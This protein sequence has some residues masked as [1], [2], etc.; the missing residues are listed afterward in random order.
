MLFRDCLDK[1]FTSAK[2]C[3]MRNA[4][5]KYELQSVYFYKNPL[6]NVKMSE[7]KGVKIVEWIEMKQEAVNDL[8]FTNR[9]GELL[10]Y[11]AVQSA[12]NA[13]FIALKLP[14]RS[15]HICRHTFATLALMTTKNL[16]AVQASLGHS[17]QKTTQVY[18]KTVALLSSETGEK[19]R[20]P[21]L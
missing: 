3:I 21:Y 14:W 12:F 11:N 13:G 17:E 4:F 7:L 2:T 15:T 9:E 18:A 1:F 16:S 5:Q 10:K 8:V 6:A 19:N 20:F